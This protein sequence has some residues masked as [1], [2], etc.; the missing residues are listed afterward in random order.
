MRVLA[1]TSICPNP[2]RPHYAPYNRQ[3]FVALARKVELRVISPISWTEEFSAWCGGKGLLRDRRRT[4]ESVVVDH[5]RYF[6]TP[7]LMRRWYGRFYCF[8]VSKSFSACLRNSGLMLFSRPG[9]IP[10]AGRRFDWGMR[11]DCLL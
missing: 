8:S 3:L 7:R 6:Y 2:Y 11:L 1:L 5:P 4:I 10:T 9:R